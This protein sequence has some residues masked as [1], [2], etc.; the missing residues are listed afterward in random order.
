MTTAAVMVDGNGVALCVGCL[1]DGLVAVYPI[2]PLGPGYNRPRPGWAVGGPWP[3]EVAR[4]GA[5]KASIFFEM[6]EKELC[7]EQTIDLPKSP[8]TVLLTEDS[9][10]RS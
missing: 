7:G 4:K 6:S 1:V 5:P 9:G 8:L 2:T 10:L 3:R